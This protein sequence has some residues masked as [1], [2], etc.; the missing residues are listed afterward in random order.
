VGG[1]IFEILSMGG[2]GYGQYGQLFDNYNWTILLWCGMVDMYGY[3]P[4]HTYHRE[5]LSKK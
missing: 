1:E 5:A 4:T 3:G 2:A